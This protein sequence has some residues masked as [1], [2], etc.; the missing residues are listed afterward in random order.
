[1]TQDFTPWGTDDDAY[2]QIMGSDVA[3]SEVTEDDIRKAADFWAEQ[4][5]PCSDG[6]LAAAIRF[7]SSQCQT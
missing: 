2:T 6:Q 3:P 1:M 4:G 5:E 7:W